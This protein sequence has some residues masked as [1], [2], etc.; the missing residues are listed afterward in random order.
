MKNSIKTNQGIVYKGN[1]HIRYKI[2]NEIKY[3]NKHNSSTINLFTAITL[4]LGGRAEDAKMFMPK[5]LMAKQ[6]DGNTYIDCFNNKVVVQDKNYYEDSTEGD[7]VQSRIS[8][9]SANNKIRYTFI[10]PVSNLIADRTI[11]R[12]QLLNENSDV[13]AEI[14]LKG[15][16]QIN[17]ELAASLLI[18]WD[19]K[20]TDSGTTVSE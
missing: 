17:T 7:I 3:I 9:G 13:C 15:N 14:D 16:E 10:V 6:Q 4:A 5:Y 19:L 11:T 20:F 18:Y 8:D 12:L 2:N 1:V